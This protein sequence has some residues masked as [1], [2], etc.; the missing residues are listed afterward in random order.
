MPRLDPSY[1]KYMAQ[2][3]ITQDFSEENFFA[4]YKQIRNQFRKYSPSSIVNTIFDYLRSPTSNSVDDL[5]KH[6]WLVFLLIK[7]V[8]LDEQFYYRGKQGISKQ[9]FMSLLG[10]MHNLGSRSIVRMPSE[11]A[12]Y[13]LF[14][15]NIS[16]Q[17][18]LYQS[19]FNG[20]AFAR[21]SLLFDKLPSNH[22]FRIEFE[23]ITNIPLSD[24]FELS[25]MLLSRFMDDNNLSIDIS[26]FSPVK[27]RYDESVVQRFLNLLSCDLDALRN[28]LIAE[29][30]NRKLRSSEYY[31][32]TLLVKFPLLKVNDVYHLWHPML[33]N[34][35]LEYSVYDILRSPNPSNF[36][37][38]FG[39]IFETYVYRSIEYLGLPYLREKQI[40]HWL[41]NTFKVTDFLITEDGANIF[42]DAKGVEIAYLGK[43][44]HNPEIVLDKVETSALKG[45]EQ[46]FQVAHCMSTQNASNPPFRASNENYLLIVTFKELYLGNG[47]D[48]YEAIAREKID[49][50]I[51]N[52]ESFPIPLE[53]IY[54]IT[55]DDLDQ[56]AN[57]VK[58]GKV[59]FVDLLRKAV[60]ED[61]S[62]STK[63]FHFRQHL[64]EFCADSGCP[65]YVDEEIENIFG[66]IEPLL[67]KN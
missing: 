62:A 23:R 44:S 26:W 66:R 56:V 54:F 6:P 5:Q 27:D 64:F 30:N 49:A 61:Q 52:G 12:H 43:V 21:Q 34:R 2:A 58:K 57:F 39:E 20:S 47:K 55:V 16:Y 40:Q 8:M 42:V 25:A 4:A 65:Q 22:T 10:R 13:H 24:F 31:E 7:W 11:Y 19:N 67:S 28:Y 63:K 50:L 33:F 51:S 60:I 46:G 32:E 29:N 17:Q 14:F 3:P 9:E 15:R 18:F 48:F 36:M 1:A 59:K 38:I 41:G 35:G 53:N 37:N 45:I